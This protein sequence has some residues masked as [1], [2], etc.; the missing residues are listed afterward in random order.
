MLNRKREKKI[1]KESNKKGDKKE[2]CGNGREQ[3]GKKK[4]TKEGDKT[5]KRRL[6]RATKNVKIKLQKKVAKKGRQRKA[7]KKKTTK[8]RR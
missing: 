2:A 6:E 5:N 8:M 7:T 1:T 3:R 4:M